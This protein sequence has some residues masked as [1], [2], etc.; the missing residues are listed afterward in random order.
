MKRKSLTAVVA[1]AA[2]SFV[3]ACGTS[4]G[5]DSSSTKDSDATTT[6]APKATTTTEASSTVAVDDWAEDFCTN[7]SAWLDDI[8]SASSD[9]GSQVTPGDIESAQ[10]A[11][12]GLFDSASQSTQELITALEDSGDPDIEDG[13]QLVNDLIEKFQAFDDAAQAAKADTE[14]LATDD[15]ATF[16]ADADQLTT[17]FQE[18]VNTVADSFSEIDAKYPSQELNSALS[19]SCSF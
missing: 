8:K 6:A 19:S 18:E 14:A 10:T 11:I 3:S 12:A 13:D 9:V 4:G 1:I 16:Q 15:I 5:D 2:L 7:F 17:D